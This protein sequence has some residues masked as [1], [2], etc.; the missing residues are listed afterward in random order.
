[1]HTETHPDIF[2]VF[3]P[4]VTRPHFEGMLAS[5]DALIWVAEMEGEAVGYAWANLVAPRGNRLG[6]RAARAGM[7]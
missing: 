7:T 5:D 4:E 3:D 2:T 6:T 1:M